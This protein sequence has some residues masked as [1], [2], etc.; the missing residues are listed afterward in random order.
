[1]PT[2]STVAVWKYCTRSTRSCEPFG[3]V[4]ATPSSKV[5]ASPRSTVVGS[6][7]SGGWLVEVVVVSAVPPQ[8][9]A[10]TSRTI[11]RCVRRRIR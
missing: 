5:S 1:M 10:S 9:A 8:A 6:V 3:W 11:A 2:S 4:C 7:V